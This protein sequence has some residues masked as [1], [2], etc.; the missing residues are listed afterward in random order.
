MLTA[1]SIS[2]FNSDFSVRV[3]GEAGYNTEYKRVR[4]FLRL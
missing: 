1:G 2:F 3:K 4:H